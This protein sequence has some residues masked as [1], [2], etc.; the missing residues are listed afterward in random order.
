M[1]LTNTIPVSLLSTKELKDLIK[2]E[3]IANINK[4]ECLAELFLRAMIKRPVI[5][6]Q[7]ACP[8]CKSENVKHGTLTL[9]DT[10]A[11]YPITCNDCNKSSKEFYNLDYIDTIGD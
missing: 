1:I 2:K 5:Y 11:Y 7:G 4:L 6:K 10:V 3:N 9:D 8:F